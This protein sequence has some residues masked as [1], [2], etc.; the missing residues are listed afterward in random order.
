MKLLP[1]GVMYGFVV[2]EIVCVCVYRR[3]EGRGRE[4]NSV[5]RLQR[6]ITSARGQEAFCKKSKHRSLERYSNCELL[7][8]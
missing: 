6:V 2:N 1:S 5:I 7:Y 4:K 8:A 3:G